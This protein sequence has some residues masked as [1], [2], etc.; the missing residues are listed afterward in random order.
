M[1]KERWR[2][3]V[4][5][6]PSY[7]EPKINV[8]TWLGELYYCSCLAVLPSPLW[9][10]LSYVLRAF[11]LGSVFTSTPLLF[12]IRMSNRKQKEKETKQ[13]INAG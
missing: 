9:V 11:I 4:A 2:L 5:L 3:S 13:P 8:C 7:T 6:V 1:E 12:G 10:L